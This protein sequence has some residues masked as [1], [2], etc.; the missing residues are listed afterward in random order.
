GHGTSPVT[1]TGP[2]TMSVSYATAAGA[3]GVFTSHATL[4]GATV[5][6]L[7]TTTFNPTGAA[8][9]AAPNNAFAGMTEFTPAT[10]ADSVHVTGAWSMGNAGVSGD[11]NLSFDST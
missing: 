1:F 2:T 6:N 5:D 10:G 11:G 9:V 4:S 8:T 3:Q 7:G